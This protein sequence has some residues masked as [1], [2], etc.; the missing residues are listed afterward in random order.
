[1]YATN[2][3]D[4]S[5]L[6]LNKN[7][8]VI[9]IIPVYKAL[10]MLIRERA[11]VVYVEDG[12]YKSYSLQNWFDFSEL[13]LAEGITDDDYLIKG[14]EKDFLVPKI[15]RTLFY[16]KVPIRGVLLTRRN[17]YLRDN[18]SCQYCG[19]KFSTEDLNIDHVIPKSRGGKMEW[20]NVV[21]SCI[22]CNT[23][24]GAST[25]QEAGMKLL[26]RPF[27]PR[28]NLSFYEKAK[29]PKYKKWKDFISDAYFNAE[30]KE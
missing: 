25:P 16:D 10:S 12:Y 4:E 5:V 22:K 11:E 24:K 7:Y 18:F 27:M 17:V 30:L 14:I 9:N 29:E 26:R 21:C 15:I 8:A 23:K 28:Y 1:M 2:V 20:N 3:L 13:K 6:V 19:R